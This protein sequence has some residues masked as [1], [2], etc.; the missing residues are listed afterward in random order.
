MKQNSRTIHKKLWNYIT[1]SWAVL[2]RVTIIFCP[3]PSVAFSPKFISSLG[4][5]SSSYSFENQPLRKKTEAQLVLEIIQFEF[6]ILSV[7]FFFHSP[8]FQPQL[9]PFLAVSTKFDSSEVQ[10]GLV[11]YHQCTSRPYRWIRTLFDC[12]QSYLVW[13]LML[14]DLGFRKL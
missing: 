5:K 7:F 11:E 8:I 9:F 4:Q 3:I 13:F 12:F 14:K 1:I 6:Q 10:E 2:D